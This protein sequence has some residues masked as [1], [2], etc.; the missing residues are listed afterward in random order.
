MDK[1]NKLDNCIQM[2]N[3]KLNS[4]KISDKDENNA[5]VKTPER[6]IIIKI[7]NAPKKKN[8]TI[9]FTNN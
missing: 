1:Y 7:P 8:N 4:I 5:I 6:P 9:L 3:K 2:V